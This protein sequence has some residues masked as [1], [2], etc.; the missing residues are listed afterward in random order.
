M[1]VV[2]KDG[3]SRSTG[4]VRMVGENF[5]GYQGKYGEIRCALDE[6]DYIAI[7]RI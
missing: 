3:H 5:F 7:E 2:Y 6:I 1:T 4:A